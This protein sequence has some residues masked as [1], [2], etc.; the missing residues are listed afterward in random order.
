LPFPVAPEVIRIQ[1]TGDT[2]LQFEQGVATATLYVPPAA[3]A[4]SNCA[5]VNVN[6]QLPAAWLTVTV[7]LPTVTPP[8]RAVAEFALLATLRFTVPF[9]VPVAGGVSVIHGAF[10]CADQEHVV[11]T[12]TCC[13]LAAAG[14]FSAVG[15]T[16]YVQS[17]SVCVTAIDTVLGGIPTVM[18]ALRVVGEGFATAVA[19]N[20]PL[21][22]PPPAGDSVIQLAFVATPHWHVV[23]TLIVEVEPPPGNVIVFGATV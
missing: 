3:G 18:I 5:G 7:A 10:D 17:P 23:V 9:P 20:V 8:V 11:A 12:C 19:V 15:V 21:P 4:S 13:V 22:V 1:P 16:T 2:A 14:T 6:A